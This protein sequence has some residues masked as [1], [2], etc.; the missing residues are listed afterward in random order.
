M[1]DWFDVLLVV[2]VGAIMLGTIRLA[3]EQ[4]LDEGWRQAGAELDHWTTLG[5]PDTLP[6]SEP[7]LRGTLP[8]YRMTADPPAQPPYEQL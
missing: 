5:S 2:I 7:A 6:E 3:W 8:Q 4:G 1:F